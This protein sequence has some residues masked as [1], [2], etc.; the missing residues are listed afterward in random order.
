MQA[1]F[2]LTVIFPPP[3]AGPEIFSCFY[4]AGTG[5]AAYAYKTPV[6]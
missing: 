4:G 5:C 3:P 2:F 1:A 6:V